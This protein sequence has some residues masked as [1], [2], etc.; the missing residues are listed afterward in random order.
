MVEN[1]AYYRVLNRKHGMYQI[2]KYLREQPMYNRG[3][4]TAP[5]M[6]DYMIRELK[7][8]NIGYITVNE[9]AEIV[10]DLGGSHIISP[11]EQKI[12]IEQLIN[13]LKN[14]TAIM[15]IIKAIHILK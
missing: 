7:N 8:Y 3:I 10:A 9:K 14:L 6:A 5:L 4:V 15:K 2:L 1:E 13:L 12:M 11:K